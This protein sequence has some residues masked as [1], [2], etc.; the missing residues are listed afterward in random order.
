VTMRILMVPMHLDA[1]IVKPGSEPA[2]QPMADFSRLPYFDG[3]RDVNSDVPY[4]SEAILS[5]PF[6]NKN[7]HLPP[8]IHLHWSLPDALT[9][10]L[11]DG[12][13]LRFPRAP[14]RWY[15]GRTVNGIVVKKWLIES[16]ALS[17]TIPAGLAPECATTYPYLQD[18]QQPFRYIG[19]IT[20]WD[21]W[22]T[23][24]V[25]GQASGFDYLDA[26][27]PL[28]AVG[29]GEPTFGAFY[30]NCASVFGAYDA[31]YPKDHYI[32]PAM[33][34]LV[35]GWY[36]DDPQGAVTELLPR[37]QGSTPV[38]EWYQDAR[39][40]LGWDISP[41]QASDTADIPTDIV[42]YAQLTFGARAD[43]NSGDA[44][45]TY[46]AP[47]DT[48]VI[49]GSTPSQALAAF[50]AHKV[51]PESQQ[52]IQDQL[53]AI[54]VA[55]QLEQSKVDTGAKFADLRHEQSFNALPG[56]RLWTLRPD[57]EARTQPGDQADDP[58]STKPD[59]LPDDLALA[60]NQLNLAQ[61][62]LDRN[63]EE[64][65][66]LYTQLYADW[67]KYM[68]CA[69]P[70]Q[71]SPVEYPDPDAAGQFL[72]QVVQSIQARS[73]DKLAA[74]LQAALSQVAAKV[75]ALMLLRAGDLLDSPAIFNTLLQLKSLAPNDSAVTSLE[76]S[77]ITTSAST[78]PWDAKSP[79]SAAVVQALLKAL[80][81]TIASMGGTDTQARIH[82]RAQLEARFT[83]AIRRRVSYYLQN[84]P[85]PRY[86]VPNE[87]VALIAGAAVRHSD[88]YD[89][90][91]PVPCTLFTDP[92]NSS[93]QMQGAMAVRFF[94]KGVDLASKVLNN[95]G[96]RT[97]QGQPWHPFL[98][99]WITALHPA[100]RD[101]SRDN[102]LCGYAPRFINNTYS[103]NE[104]DVDLQLN[105]AGTQFEPT[106]RAFRGRSILSRHAENNLTRHLSAYLSRNLPA[107]IK[108]DFPAGAE[109]LDRYLKSPSPADTN[110]RVVD[111]V[112]AK[113]Q[114]GI[115]AG[116]Y[117]DASPACTALHAYAQLVDTPSLAQSLDGFNQ[118]LLMQKQTLQLAPDDPLGFS[119]IR[120]ITDLVRQAIAE[121]QSTGPQP[122]NDFNP[123]R[124][125]AVE[126]QYLRL[127]DA[128]GQ[129]I[130]L[131]TSTVLS[132]HSAAGLTH[133][134]NGLL[135]P[136]RLVQ[137]ARLDFRFLAARLSA[138]QGQPPL[139]MSSHP[140]TTPICGWLVPNLLDS[141]LSVHAESGQALGVIRKFGS[142][143]EWDIA[144]GERYCRLENIPNS[145]LARVVNE[146]LERS[147][148]QPAFLDEF[149]LSIHDALE[150]I[151]PEGHKHH[152]AISL[153][154]A[155]PLAV[156]R[157]SLNLQLKGLPAN[158]QSW[159]V[160]S[161]ELEQFTPLASGDLPRETCNFTR[162]Q[163][164]IRL[165]EYQRLNDGLVGFWQETTGANGDPGALQHGFYVNDSE[166]AVVS[167]PNADKLNGL[168]A[169]PVKKALQAAGG[170]IH[171][172][173]FLAGWKDGD[174]IWNLL[175]TSGAIKP[176]SFHSLQ[177][178][179][180]TTR[181]D[182]IYYADAPDLMQSI[183]SPPI[184]LTMLIDPRGV[185]H[186]TSGI[187]P[188]KSIQIPAEMFAKAM[189][190]IEINLAS[191]MVLAHPGRT[192]LPLPEEPGFFWSWLEL[193]KGEWDESPNAAPPP[194]TEDFGPL[195]IQE[196]WLKLRRTTRGGE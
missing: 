36:S 19:R 25:N 143:V 49:F 14:N 18:P 108:Q 99:E 132:G 6:A 105:T 20:D 119:E 53:E 81:D 31:D 158:N 64:K 178:A 141:S 116:T 17:R 160:F 58:T 117:A 156:V 62:A 2:I 172:L 77:L 171:K 120:K 173:A 184:T 118:A 8:G 90:H 91:G 161:Q 114:A 133:E 101:I 65:A 33:S 149:L 67:S 103:L 51:N 28:T 174:G 26:N 152:D 163:F 37:P 167:D 74:A 136:P 131:D 48:Q 122:F 72:M 80:N 89:L 129:T 63:Q 135:L 42:C 41:D 182:L 39:D 47:A 102:P 179:K 112:L 83:N 139:E 66:S 22:Y 142:T 10:G 100:P 12:A 98:L 13:N 170:R 96:L 190:S 159:Q 140:G 125:G 71:D 45:L 145:H 86:W 57:S 196:G 181:P 185:V 166:P 34:Y 169:E 187:Q 5:E 24:Q 87:P 56:G 54:L 150:N 59:Y 11:S 70:P 38:S 79:F 162:V 177:P 138:G 78:V 148:A 147:K 30:P 82:V 69:Y 183:E 121:G 115:E 110:K 113:Y 106:E 35:I 195:E 84:V 157:A 15:I 68:L 134:A 7:L 52:S 61:T 44:R 151:E 40:K 164:P 27:H 85:A 175:Q 46:G 16:D 127:V 186:A 188:V 128:F 1:L 9:R 146:L 4:L 153:F 94:A 111:D 92:G 192:E 194:T 3:Q 107:E 76:K 104:M 123:I 21:S 60:L 109:E 130:D 176:L 165:G 189:R 155:H 180:D 23:Q 193:G 73:D 95:P 43:L 75:N 191:T 88:R 124:S 126:I 50:L 154:M 168:D 93:S 144:P 137:P 97:W 29:Y 55:A 32:P